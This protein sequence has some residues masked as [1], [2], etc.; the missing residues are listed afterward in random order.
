LR[1]AAQLGIFCKAFLYE[2]LRAGFS[3]ETAQISALLFGQ[4][5]LTSRPSCAMLT[6][7]F[8]IVFRMRNPG[9]TACK[10]APKVQRAANSQAKRPGF[11]ETLE[12]HV[13]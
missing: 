2:N 5:L 6:F 9:E 10:A 3:G 1:R 11:D 12:S 4:V 8:Y 7:K 13:S